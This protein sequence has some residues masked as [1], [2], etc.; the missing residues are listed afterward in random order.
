MLLNNFSALSYSRRYM[1]EVLPIRRKTR[2]N[3]SFNQSIKQYQYVKNVRIYFNFIS[4]RF[5]YMISQFSY[6]NQP[7]SPTI[8]EK[9]LK[10]CL[11]F[12]F[13]RICG[14]V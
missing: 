10:K 8:S 1:A 7:L 4:N 3:Q 12:W 6:S 11:G 9:I 2:S 5:R 13:L 14:Q